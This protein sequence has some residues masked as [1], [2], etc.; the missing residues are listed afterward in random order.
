MVCER[1]VKPTEVTKGRNGASAHQHLHI[2][3]MVPPSYFPK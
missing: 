2:L 3:A 1:L